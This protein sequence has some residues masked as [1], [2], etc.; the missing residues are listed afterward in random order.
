MEY[1]DA[2]LWILLGYLGGQWH[3]GRIHKKN[4]EKIFQ[5]ANEVSVMLAEMKKNMSDPLKDQK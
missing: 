3:A 4:Y 1:I 5:K 2:L